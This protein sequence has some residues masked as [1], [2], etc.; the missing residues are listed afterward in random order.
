M[1]LNMSWVVK[2]VITQA[3]VRRGGNASSAWI[4]LNSSESKKS[5]S[6]CLSPLPRQPSWS[7][8][9]SLLCATRFNTNTNTNTKWSQL[10]MKSLVCNKEKKGVC[11]K[12]NLEIAG[13]TVVTRSDQFPFIARINIITLHWITLHCIKLR[14]IALNYVTL[15]CITLQAHDEQLTPF[16]SLTFGGTFRG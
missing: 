14:Y 8:G 4:V 7:D 5:W 6:T 12:S 15:H 9:W 2:S 11:C 16:W 1:L 13:G 3:I 10:L